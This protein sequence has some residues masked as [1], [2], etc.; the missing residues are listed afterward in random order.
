MDNI[1][2]QCKIWP[3]FEYKINILIFLFKSLLGIVASY[4]FYKAVTKATSR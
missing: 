2:K 1:D 4:F 3:L